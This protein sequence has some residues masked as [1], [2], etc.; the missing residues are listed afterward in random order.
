M[1]ETNGIAPLLAI[2]KI[3]H[4]QFDKCPEVA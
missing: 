3:V 2:W 1:D 4:I